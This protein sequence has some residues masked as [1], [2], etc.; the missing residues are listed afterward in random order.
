MFFSYSLA[1]AVAAGLLPER[2]SCFLDH[3]NLEMSESL[4]RNNRIPLIDLRSLDCIVTVE[5][6]CWI[7]RREMKRE[8]CVRFVS[9]RI[10]VLKNN[11]LT[12]RKKSS[13]SDEQQTSGEHVE[14]TLSNVCTPP[15]GGVQTYRTSENA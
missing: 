2:V 14:R 13:Q 7:A 12:K 8:P 10:F 3:T 11:N 5:R 6:T 9:F 4:R 1:S 15:I